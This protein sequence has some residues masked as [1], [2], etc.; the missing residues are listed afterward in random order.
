MPLAFRLIRST[1]RRAGLPGLSLASIVEYV[2]RDSS[3][4]AADERSVRPCTASVGSARQ[5]RRSRQNTAAGVAPVLHAVSRRARNVEDAPHHR[6]SS[7]ADVAL[8]AT[9][10]RLVER[11]KEAT[12]RRAIHQ[13][14]DSA[15]GD[16]RHVLRVCLPGERESLLIAR[17]EDAPSAVGVHESPHQRAGRVVGS[18]DL[19]HG[20]TAPERDGL[21]Q[22]RRARRATHE[23]GGR[24]EQQHTITTPC[25]RG[26]GVGQRPSAT[27]D[28][29]PVADAHR[30]EHRRDRAGRRNRLPNRSRGRRP[31]P[32]HDA[33]TI[34]RIDG[35]HA[36]APVKRRAPP[37]DLVP[38]R[39]DRPSPFREGP[40]HQRPDRRADPGGDRSG[41]DGDVRYVSPRPIRVRERR[42]R[43]P[44]GPR[45]DGSHRPWPTPA[46]VA[47]GPPQDSP[48]RSNRRSS[49]QT[50]GSRGRRRP[51]ASSYPARTPVIHASPSSP[52][53][54]STRTLGGLSSKRAIGGSVLG[55]RG[56]LLSV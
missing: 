6:S 27:V 37:V 54:P 9:L 5:K 40:Q 55:M 36:Q 31:A 25:R 22:G 46:G 14:G 30:S 35:A 13:L 24:L 41:A 45:P 7:R 20:A 43:T 51:V 4:M 56:Q 39:G 10:V 48:Q 53:P 34:A 44:P 16:A 2:T 1:A 52:P 12:N 18:D 8:K 49:R 50:A 21:K 26:I 23:H 28:V 15:L 11:T 38:E 47:I 17:R 33:A 3:E 29:Q 19:R 32:E 42:R